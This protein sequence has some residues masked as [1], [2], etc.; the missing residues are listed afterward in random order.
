MVYIYVV[1]QKKISVCDKQI[2]GPRYIF[3]LQQVSV[4][5]SMG[6]S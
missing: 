6:M 2:S 4:A 3:M 1:I 5:R